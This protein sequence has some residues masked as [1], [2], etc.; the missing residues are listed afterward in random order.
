MKNKFYLGAALIAACLLSMNVNA[1]L[2]VTTNGHVVISKHVATNGTA[3]SDSVALRTK[4]PTTAS[5]NRLYG[6]Y[7]SSV[8]NPD[9]T[10]ALGANVCVVGQVTSSAKDGGDPRTNQLFQAAV[11]GVAIQGIGVYG[12]TR[13]TI[14]VSL[15]T[16]N[17]AGYFAGNA[18]VTGTLT[19]AA[20]TTTSDRRFK[21]NISPLGTDF[22]TGVL[23]QLTPV[24]YTFKENDNIYNDIKEP[25]ITH[26]GLIAQDVQEIAP[27]LVYE[28]GDG[29]LSI[30]YTELIPLL[31]QVV[32]S[33]QQQITDLQLKIQKLQIK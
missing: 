23:S 33:Q 10:G 3:V 24:S 4:V 32:N 21:Q 17:F 26:Y 15:S 9:P 29:Y 12:A 1:Q 14:P 22:S 19:A 11:A 31:I 27:E 20:V 6:I 28:D 2:E 5:G 30:N 8:A 25:S 7:S 18:K 16:G 13:Y